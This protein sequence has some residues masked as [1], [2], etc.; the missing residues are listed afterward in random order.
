MRVVFL[1]A[2]PVELWA[3]SIGGIY[4]ESPT[5]AILAGRQM[6]YRYSWEIQRGLAER[7]ITAARESLRKLDV[8]A[9]AHVYTGSLKKL[10]ATFAAEQE[11][12]LMMTSRSSRR[13]RRIAG[14]I[15]LLGFLD[16]PRPVPVT[17]LHV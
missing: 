8:E 1:L 4:T 2:Y 14:R 16:R 7:K 12:H 6:D 5:K 10:L 9:A 15:P 13:W 11:T 3:Y 17:L